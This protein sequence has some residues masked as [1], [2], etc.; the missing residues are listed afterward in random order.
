MHEMTDSIPIIIMVVLFV[1]KT[2][3][4]HSLKLNVLCMRV[5]VSVC[6]GYELKVDRKSPIII[7]GEPYE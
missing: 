2:R 6:V 5:C 1:D 7:K 4:R 3:V